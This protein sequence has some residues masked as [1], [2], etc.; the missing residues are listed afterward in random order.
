MLLWI[1]GAQ[2]PSNL[3]IRSKEAGESEGERKRGIRLEKREMERSG[4]GRRRKRGGERM[5]VSNGK[6][7]CGLMTGNQNQDSGAE[8][9][10]SVFVRTVRA[11]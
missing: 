1:N 7:C 11:G 2:L 9:V 8:R 10:Q 6:E 5:V 4:E 3:L